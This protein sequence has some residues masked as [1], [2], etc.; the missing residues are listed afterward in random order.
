MEQHMDERRRP[1]QA[2]LERG[3][4]DA[5]A[6]YERQ[7]QRITTAVAPQGPWE[8]LYPIPSREPSRE[9]FHTEPVIAWGLLDRGY[10]A[11]VTPSRLHGVVGEQYALRRCCGEE[12]TVYAPFATARD[13]GADVVGKFSD[14][15]A[16]LRHREQQRAAHAKAT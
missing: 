7:F 8:I 6:E 15:A 14:A 5:I 2:D 16:W 13:A 4:R 11:P 12:E 1:T 9:T 10:F 3:E